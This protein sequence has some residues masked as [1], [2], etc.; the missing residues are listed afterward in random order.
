MNPGHSRSGMRADGDD[1][2]IAAFWKRYAAVLEAARIPEKRHVW[3]RRA[4]ERFIVWLQP[5]RLAQTQR[6][7]VLE[8]LKYLEGARLERW[9]LEQASEALRYLLA[10]VYGC[11]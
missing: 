4:C 5:T 7:Q 8:Y 2:R 3:F 9:Q 10:D 11:G 1:P 6:E